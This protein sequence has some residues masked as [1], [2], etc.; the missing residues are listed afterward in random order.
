MMSFPWVRKAVEDGDITLHAW[1]FDMSNGKLFGYDF[2]AHS[3]KE[4]NGSSLGF[5]KETIAHHG[6]CD[7]LSAEHVA[8]QLAPKK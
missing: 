4:I 6:C 8:K 1:Y 3:F 5:S 7:T 2:N